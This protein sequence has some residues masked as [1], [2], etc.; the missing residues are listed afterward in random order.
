MP[1]AVGVGLEKDGARRVFGGVRGNSKGGREVREAEDGFREE[2]TFEGIKG[3]LAG[4]GPIP[5]EIL[6]GEIEE[7]ASDVGIVGDES[8]VEIGETKE[9]VDIFHLGRRG[10]V[11]DAVKLDGVHGE[12]AGFHD[13]SKIFH[14]VG[15]ELALLKFQVE[16]K[17]GHAL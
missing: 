14:L 10:P 12:F 9:K 1:I 15:G 11:C 5:R 13:H 8:S 17:L 7:R 16:V 2:E 6:L 4:G 3:G